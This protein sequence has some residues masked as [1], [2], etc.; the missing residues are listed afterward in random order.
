MLR[1][2]TLVCNLVYATARR[3]GVYTLA[4]FAASRY[5]KRAEKSPCPLE[6]SSGRRNSHLEEM[7]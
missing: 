7:E 5:R 2:Y 4:L 1:N 6:L 3:K